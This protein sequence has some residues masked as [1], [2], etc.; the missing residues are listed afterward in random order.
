M[1]GPQLNAC[2]FRSA[3]TQSDAE[4]S[5][6]KAFWVRNFLLAGT[7]LPRSIFVRV[8]TGQ[9]NF[10][11]LGQQST[12]GHVIFKIRGQLFTPGATEGEG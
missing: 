6:K 11:I 7:Q 12:T 9:V 5:K 10:K 3:A 4:L 1:H 2:V 8:A